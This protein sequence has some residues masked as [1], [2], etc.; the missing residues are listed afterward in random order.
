MTTY[1]QQTRTLVLAL[2]SGLAIAATSLAPCAGTNTGLQGRT[3]V[4]KAHSPDF[5]IPKGELT[6]RFE[7]GRIGGRGGINTFFGSYTLQDG[8][9]AVSGIG[10]TKMAGDP[11]LM[12]QE[13]L[14]FQALEKVVGFEASAYRLVLKDA[15]GRFL[16]LFEP[17]GVSE[18]NR[19][20]IHAPTSGEPVGPN[21]TV[22]GRT[23]SSRQGVINIVTDVYADGRLW[24]SVPGHRDRTTS[25]GKYRMRIATPRPKES[26]AGKLRY[27][28]RVVELDSKDQPRGPEAWVVLLARD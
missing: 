5:R 10:S 1:P 27:V 7:N 6:V 2:I 24:A 3:W 19:P 18:A 12:V 8:K 11:D 15:D 25:T 20:I 22:A 21:V 16:L 13:S 26:I 17:E 4:L 28:V 9:L 14:Y 23:G